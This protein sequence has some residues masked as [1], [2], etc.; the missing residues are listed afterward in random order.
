[1][2]QENLLLWLK[3]ISRFLKKKSG[4]VYLEKEKYGIDECKKVAQKNVLPFIS[5]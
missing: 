3:A 4:V 2:V 5:T 1:M